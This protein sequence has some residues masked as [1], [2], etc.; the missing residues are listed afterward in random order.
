MAGEEVRSPATGTVWVVNK[1]VG[2]AV[3]AMEDILI[4]ESMKMEIGVE[5]VVRGS[6]VEIRVAEGNLVEEGQIVAVIDVS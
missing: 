6:V 1:K 5:P 2:E 4:L 3:A